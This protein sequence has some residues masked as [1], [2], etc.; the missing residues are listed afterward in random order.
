MAVNLIAT[1]QGALNFLKAAYDWQETTLAGHWHVHLFANAHTVTDA[2]V[3]GDF[4]ESSFVGYA[5]A[6]PTWSTPANV[7]GVPTST[8]ATVTFTQ[9]SAWPSTSYG[10][11]VTDSTNA[12]LLGA[13]NFVSPVV[14]T[15]SQPSYALT[16]SITFKPE[17]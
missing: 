10:V 8:S 14:L 7:A 16:V 13:A 9:T 1:T 5:A 4:T 6:A 12:L 2:S 11:Y 17:Y 3:I 15:A